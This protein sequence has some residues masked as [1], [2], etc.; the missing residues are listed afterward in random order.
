M[1]AV[2]T[3]ATGL[4]GQALI[5]QLGFGVAVLSRDDGR[6]QRQL[7]GVRVHRW[8]PEGG[9]AP[10]EAL[11][12]ADIV[13]NLA[14]EPA[15]D[16]RWTAEKKRCIRDSRVVGTRHLVAGLAAL[17]ERPRVLVSASAVGYYGDRG[18][19]LLDERSSRGQGFLADVCVDWEREAM[20]A[21]RLGIRVVCVRI[22]LVMST[23][24]GALAKMLPPFRLGAGGRL[25]SGRQWMPWIHIDDLVGIL[26]HAA[27]SESS[28]G[29]INGVAPEPVTNAAFTAALAHAVHR[30]AVLPMPAF[31]LNVAFGEMSGMLM[32]SQRVMPAL[33]L[34]S[35]YTFSHP[36]LDGALASL[37]SPEARRDAA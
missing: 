26:L 27:R 2:V 3:G 12:G 25:G 37:L 6:A 14:G 15:A 21:E 11:R 35:G 13:F 5:R 22:G 1:Q 30:P 8:A 19:E 20:V 36:D 31:A 17:N 10:V 23:A 28:R 18:D 4:I 34:R 7:V 24:G 33:A 9:P 16:G 32:A 29:P